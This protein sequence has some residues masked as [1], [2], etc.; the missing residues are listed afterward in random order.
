LVGQ[1]VRWEGSGK[2]RK[3]VVTPPAPETM[4]TIRDLV[5]GVTGLDAA[6]G[7]QLVVETLPFESNNTIG[8]PAQFAP[9][10]SQKTELQPPWLEAINKYRNVLF[11][12]V[13]GLVVLGILIKIV[14]RYLPGRAASRVAV[15]RT[16]DELDVAAAMR[17][18]SAQNSPSPGAGA[19]YQDP[20]LAEAHA[21][22]ADR[23]RQ[24]AQ[25]DPSA[26]A[27]VIRMWLH[28]QRES[29]KV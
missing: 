25:K 28:P 15:E 18:I 5:A 29:Q 22:T 16:N 3:Q 6:R 17:G 11:M 27:N 4:K 23:I 13:G 2:T 10:S 7:D 24:L 8:D 21:E 20:L 9:V 14:L 12:A 1:P 26:S 19:G